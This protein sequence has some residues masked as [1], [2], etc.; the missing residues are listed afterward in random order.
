M[1]PWPLISASPARTVLKIPL[2]EGLPRLVLDTN[3]SLDWLVFGDPG[4]QPLVAAIR[5]RQVLW[6]ACPRMRDE[7]AHLL[8]HASLARWQPDAAQ[9][10][11]QFDRWASLQPEPPVAPRLRCSDADDQVFVDLALAHRVRW[12][13]SHDRAVLKLG[14]RL[15]LHGVA[16]M[17]PA[18]WGAAALPAP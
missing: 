14:R 11:A 9:A 3:V 13:I 1:P 15:R 17:K 12:L 8:G 5:A 16:V 7:L 10:L 18:Q 4:V 6:L 2:S